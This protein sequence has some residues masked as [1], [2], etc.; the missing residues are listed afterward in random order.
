MNSG[1]KTL[2]S[3][4]FPRLCG[5]CIQAVSDTR[6]L[7]PDTFLGQHAAISC[8]PS[9][10]AS[11]GWS[12]NRVRS[13]RLRLHFYYT[14][15]SFAG[16]FEPGL[17]GSSQYLFWGQGR[18]HNFF[19]A[20]KINGDRSYCL[21]VTLKKGLIHGA[22]GISPIMSLEKDEVYSNKPSG[23]TRPIQVVHKIPA[24]KLLYLCTRNRTTGS[25]QKQI[26]A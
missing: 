15:N 11:A 5:N 4:A 20:L 3:S 24:C 14:R 18:N 17:K 26:A 8:Q 25:Y 6:Q 22:A 12:A 2:N 9:P 23:S 7:T 19:N 16:K 10:G 13:R 21:S 1:P